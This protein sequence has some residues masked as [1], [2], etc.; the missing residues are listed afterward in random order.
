MELTSRWRGFISGPGARRATILLVIL[1]LAGCGADLITEQWW[2]MSAIC[3]VA[4]SGLAR[5]IGY[6]S[7]LVLALSWAAGL[8]AVRWPP[9]RPLYWALLLAM[10]AAFMAQQ[11]LLDRGL[12][13]CDGP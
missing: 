3:L 12:L 1:H 2:L 13:S 7:W 8:L 6:G 5:A 4:A 11:S 9:A 10:P